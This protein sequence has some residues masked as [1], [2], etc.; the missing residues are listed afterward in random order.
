MANGGVTGGKRGDIRMGYPLERK[1]NMD[2]R[3]FAEGDGG[4]GVQEGV[5]GEGETP[6][7]AHVMQDTPAGRKRGRQPGPAEHIRPAAEGMRGQRRA[8]ENRD[9][10]RR[11]R[12]QG[13]GSAPG[14]QA[15]FERLI[16]GD[17]KDLFE[18]RAQRIID[19]R[20]KQTKALEKR[21]E[22]LSPMVSALEAKFGVEPGDVTA[23]QRALEEDG[24]ASQPETA[25]RGRDADRERSRE[26]GRSGEMNLRFA[27]WARQAQSVRAMY[28]GFDLAREMN[29]P[30][31]GQAFFH[32]LMSQVPVRTAY[33][34]VHKDELLAGAMEYTAHQIQKKTLD[35]IRARGLRPAENG[36]AGRATAEVKADM[37]SL[38]RAE[39]REIE[40][41]AARGER[42]SF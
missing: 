14:R 21:L 8:L 30:R 20:F 41:R 24:N 26:H 38:T 25:E 35:D 31:R 16:K 9:G 10:D 40:R 28:P 17:Y 18:E 11:A 33:E 4:T 19:E 3:L 34:V 37:R 12:P 5:S 13:Q 1:K 42:V 7:A 22:A 39:R 32:L 27:E 36:A 6:A 23:L 29:D 15:A 2:L